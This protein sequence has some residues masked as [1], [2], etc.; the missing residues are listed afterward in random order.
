MAM[1]RLK[2]MFP[3]A[4]AS[5][6]AGSRVASRSSS[7]T[8]R[9]S[10]SRSITACESLPSESRAPASRSRRAGPMPSARSR[11]VVGQRQQ[12][13]PA[14]PRSPMSTSVIC[15]ACTAVKRSLS[16]PASASTPVGDRPCAARLP[17]FSAGCSDT[18]ACSCAERDAAHD[19]T[20]PADAGST[21]RTLCTAAPTRTPLSMLSTRRTHAS[22]SPSEN[23]I[24][25]WSKAAPKPPRR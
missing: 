4:K 25:T 16:A 19:A 18:W 8:A 14:S 11:S 21:A 17:S 24:C 12:V 9:A 10:S 7:S 23:R 15:V 13:E 1:A 6:V 5:R 3:A 22:A 20:T 2:S